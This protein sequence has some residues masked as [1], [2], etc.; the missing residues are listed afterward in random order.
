[1]TS[2]MSLHKRKYNKFL[3]MSKLINIYSPHESCSMFTAYTWFNYGSVETIN[4]FNV[5]LSLDSLLFLIAALQN[6][7]SRVLRG[8]LQ[9]LLLK[10]FSNMTMSMKF[11]M[12]NNNNNPKNLR[13]H[14]NQ[15]KKHLLMCKHKIL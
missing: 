7:T 15:N 8:L 2:S 3:I 4:E 13:W 11:L 14:S 12:K 10:S 1:M 5:L 9:V 6:P